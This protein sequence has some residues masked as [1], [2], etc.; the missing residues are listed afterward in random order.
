MSRNDANLKQLQLENLIT[1]YK[2]NIKNNEDVI[3]KIDEKI[4]DWNNS[5][6]WMN[7]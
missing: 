1:L 6:F 7:K 5:I 4:S 3:K 2:I